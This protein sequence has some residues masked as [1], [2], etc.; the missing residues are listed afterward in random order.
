M[1]KGLADKGLLTGGFEIMMRGTTKN[2][3][4]KV[5]YPSLL[6]LMEKWKPQDQMLV[7]NRELTK[8]MLRGWISSCT[9]ITDGNHRKAQEVLTIPP[10]ARG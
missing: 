6:G 4:N 1:S 7:V 10:S 9:I 8:D 3:R 2:D 5:I